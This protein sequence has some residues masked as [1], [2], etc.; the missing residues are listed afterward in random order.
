MGPFPPVNPVPTIASHTYGES[1]GDAPPP[2]QAYPAPEVPSITYTQ[3]IA[4][5]PSAAHE[6]PMP[7]AQVAQDSMQTAGREPRHSQR[8]TRAYDPV[9]GQKANRPRERGRGR[10]RGAPNYRTQEVETLLDLV[11]DELPIASKG[12]RVVGARFRDW[13]IVTQA[14]ARTDRSLELKFKQVCFLI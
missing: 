10:T 1:G 13:A 11:E 12:W 14:P 9:R 7:V 2:T 4:Q 6:N 3:P 8:L 5:L